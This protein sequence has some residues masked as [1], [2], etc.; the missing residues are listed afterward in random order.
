[1]KNTADSKL[2]VKVLDMTGRTLIVTNILNN[3]TIDVES[4]KSGLYFIMVENKTEKVT[5]SF[6]K[7]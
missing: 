2:L 7:N 5:Q 6:V 1:M 4:I 3:S